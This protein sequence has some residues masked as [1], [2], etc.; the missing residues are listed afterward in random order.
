MAVFTAPAVGAPCLDTTLGGDA[1]N[2]Y[3]TV[4]ELT[5]FLR[6]RVSSSGDTTSSDSLLKPLFDAISDNTML[7]EGLLLRSTT[8][9][10]QHADRFIGRRVDDGQALE[11]PRVYAYRA[12]PRRVYPST[13]IPDDIKVAQV[14]FCA[15]LQAKADPFSILPLGINED[16]TAEPG[17][18]TQGVVTREGTLTE[19]SY[20]RGLYTV[21]YSPREESSTTTTRTNKIVT[22]TKSNSRGLGY[23]DRSIEHYMLGAVDIMRPLFRSL[24]RTGRRMV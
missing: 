20:L 18:V 2:C 12:S 11:W 22:E 23:N 15:Y 13:S 1:A 3:I 5:N 16:V 19:E 14:Y 10:D 17:S 4:E 6:C 8:Y 21:R 24:Y 7:A 9:I